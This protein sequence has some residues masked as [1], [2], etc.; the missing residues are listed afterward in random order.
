MSELA[1]YSPDES[2]GPAELPPRA[3][4][5]RSGHLFGT[6]PKICLPT[7]CGLFAY[8]PELDPGGHRKRSTMLEPGAGHNSEPTDEAF[9][10]AP[11]CPHGSLR[12]KPCESPRRPLSLSVNVRCDA[13]AVRG[14]PAEG[15]EA[16]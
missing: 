5:G 8:V 11:A 15:E 12:R 13:I 6:S 9:E 7:P 14:R 2:W 16:T 4:G 3:L 1:R 10:A